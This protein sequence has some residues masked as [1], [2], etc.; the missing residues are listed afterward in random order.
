MASNVQF[1]AVKYASLLFN[2]SSSFGVVKCSGK[3]LIAKANRRK[4]KEVCIKYSFTCLQKNGEDTGSVCCAWKRY[5]KPSQLK[6]DLNNTHKE[7]VNLVPKSKIGCLKRVRLDA[8]GAFNRVNFPLL[9][10]PMWLHFALLKWKS[11][12]PL[13]KSWWSHASWIVLK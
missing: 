2:D 13:Q 9:R 4:C 10:H 8:G 1:V 12:I 11:F 6:Q 3:M 5:L 7:Q